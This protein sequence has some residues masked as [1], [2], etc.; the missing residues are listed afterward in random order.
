MSEK[1][2]KKSEG[3]NKLVLYLLGLASVFVVLYG[4][5]EMAIII[6]PILLA[7]VI[8][9]SVIPIHAY[10]K[11]HGFANWISILVTI[12]LVIGILGSVIVTMFV[13]ITRLSIE[14]P[15]YI[16]QLSVQ[17]NSDW[18]TNIINTLGINTSSIID[19]IPYVERIISII[20]TSISEFGVT[21]LI[22]VFMLIAAISFHS[23]AKKDL[24]ISSSMLD[25]I[26]DI[27]KDIRKYVNTLTFLN[28]L[29]AIGNMILLMILGVPYAVLWAI[30]SWFMGYIPTIGFIIALIPPAILGY[31]ID[32][33]VAAII[34]TVGYIIING[35]VQN[36]I[37]PKLMGDKLN[38]S[39]VI[40]FISIFF[41]GY[42]LGGIGVLLCIPLTLVVIMILENIDSTKWIAEIMRYNGKASP[43]ESKT[44]IK[45]AKRMAEKINLF[46]K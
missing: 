7:I 37:Q 28:L 32:G 35:G 5:R 41:W 4:I 27:T 1:S 15:N 26:S 31:L 9:I 25:K 19:I 12:L 16:T 14:I 10:L 45:K 33:P 39:P 17:I 46:G 6:N 20:L 2:V 22:F 43:K 8:T 44:A 36:I 13:S 42:L 11:K 21:L 23:R 29:V 40:V 30:L 38:I 18:S 3:L 24:N 34:I